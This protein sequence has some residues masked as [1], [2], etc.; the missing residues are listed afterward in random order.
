LAGTS[1][2]DPGGDLVPGERAL[3]EINDVLR[4]GPN[5]G[6]TLLVI[7]FD[8]HGGLYDH[9]PP[10][11]ADNPW[12]NDMLDGFR[13]DLMGPRV[14]TILVS[15]WSSEKTVFR[16]ETDVPYDLTSALATLLK[17]SGIPQSKWGLGVRTH[18]APT[19]EGVFRE[20]QARADSPSFTPPYDKSFPPDGRSQPVARL[21]DL[22]RLMAPRLIHA[23]PRDRVSGAEIEKLADEAVSAGWRSCRPMRG[24]CCRGRWSA[25]H[26][27]VKRRRSIWLS[28]TTS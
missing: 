2:Y 6:E 21:H 7:T 24:I 16:S 22:H 4:A 26:W 10:P 28:A 1:S 17:W 23:L 12:P 19:F 25:V 5:W 15:P 18:R 3:N 8:E 27:K 13:Y 20:P 14:P 11:R 9:V